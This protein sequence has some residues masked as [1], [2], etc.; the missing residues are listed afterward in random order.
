MSNI[1]ENFLPWKFSSQHSFCFFSKNF[2]DIF[3]CGYFFREFLENLYDAFFSKNFWKHSSP[4]IFSAISSILRRGISWIFRNIILYF[5]Y[6][7][8]IVN[9]QRRILCF[10]D[11]EDQYLSECRYFHKDLIISTGNRF[12]LWKYYQMTAISTKSFGF[13]NLKLLIT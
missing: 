11:I 4:W 5:H 1:F 9:T 2:C 13:W 6:D 8:D 12:F 10:I 7:F 3:H